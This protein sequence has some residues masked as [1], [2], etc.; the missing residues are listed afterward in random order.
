MPTEQDKV[1]SDS[2]NTLMEQLSECPEELLVCIAKEISQFVQ[3][4]IYI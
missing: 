2:N 4:P 1:D 3:P